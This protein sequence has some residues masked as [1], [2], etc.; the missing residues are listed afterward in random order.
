AVALKT[1]HIIAKNVVIF[2]IGCT[3]RLYHTINMDTKVREIRG[4]KN[5]PDYV[6]TAAPMGLGAINLN[7]P[8]LSENNA[9]VVVKALTLGF[10][11][12]FSG[13][14]NS[15]DG[16]RLIYSGLCVRFDNLLFV[17]VTGLK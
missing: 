9:R 8:F 6:G 7:L 16:Y 10:F 5:R 13:C 17:S 12:I 11:W 1:L 3:Y 2:F 15:L 14:Y 4:I